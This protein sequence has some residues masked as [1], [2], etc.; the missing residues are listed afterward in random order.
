M[1][2]AA[3][4]VPVLINML[5]TSYGIQSVKGETRKII[6]PD[7]FSNI[8]D[9]I[10][11]ATKGDTIFVRGGAYKQDVIVNKTIL[12][13]GESRQNTAIT[14]WDDSKNALWI[15]A[16]NVTISGFTI[17]TGKSG[18]YMDGV[19]GARIIGNRVA[20]NTGTGI[21]DGIYMRSSSGNLISQNI[22]ANNK[23]DGLTLALN[24]TF[25]TVSQ[26]QI[27]LN[28]GIGVYLQDLSDRN[29]ITCNDISFNKDGI[30]M[31]NVHNNRIVAN[32]ISSNA[33]AQV[34][35]CASVSSNAFY[36]N[37]FIVGDTASKPI[38][39]W[40]SFTN[41][42]WGNYWNTYT[43]VDENGDGIGDVQYSNSTAPA[44]TDFHPENVTDYYPLI[45]PWTS[46]RVFNYTY[47]QQKS[48][49]IHITNNSTTIYDS[50]FDRT[51][52]MIVFKATG[53]VGSSTF[54]NVSIPRCLLDA[55]P[56]EWKTEINSQTVN[57]D[58]LQDRNDTHLCFFFPSSD[59]TIVQIEGTSPIDDT[60]P[61]VELGP[62]QTI[63][64][65]MNL[66][67]N[68]SSCSD[69]T[70]ISKY[71][72]TFIDRTPQFL[73]GVAPNHTFN[74]PGLYRITLNVTDLRGNS[75]TKET[76]VTV[77]GFPVWIEPWFWPTAL[78]VVILFGSALFGVR[79]YRNFKK[80]RKIIDQYKQK[81]PNSISNHRDRA[82]LL[83]AID[84]VDRQ[85]KIE[86]FAEIHGIRIR[87]AGS[88][89]ELDD[90]LGIHKKP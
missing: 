39:S 76:W 22:I 66:I 71:V 53:S 32:N 77:Q 69:D 50:S 28:L 58:V 79:Y 36:H 80:Q 7:D 55:S 67:L 18:I 59:N 21:G 44:L 33:E 49:S 85:P 38:K 6:V 70:C 37:N 52:K 16:D 42:A 62:N 30:Y 60:P 41:E 12:L 46:M 2:L 43:G 1:L 48:Y 25:N 10:N 9:A 3:L 4:F 35:L 81:L 31:T 56:N 89:E 40:D 24:S 90:K 74:N 87:P 29:L 75:A 11:D 82:R 64:E 19:S 27:T 68:A 14:P 13:I 65:G 15:D 61:I 73:T 84:N 23:E 86:R 88:L 47:R 72:W 26:N 83:I 17:M 20:Y 57:R 45:S 5:S 78:L 8:Q 34:L 54:C 51:Q 63:N